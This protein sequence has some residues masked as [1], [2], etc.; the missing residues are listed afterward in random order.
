MPRSL[1]RGYAA[2][3]LLWRQFGKARECTGEFLECERTR[4]FCGRLEHP[5]PACARGMRAALRHKGAEQS[6]F[7]M[8]EHCSAEYYC[9]MNT[10]PKLYILGKN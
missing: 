3:V 9:N 2:A 10:A 5:A 4:H 7:E 6:R 8:L 1:L